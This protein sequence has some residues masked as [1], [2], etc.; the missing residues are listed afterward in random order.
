MP[1]GRRSRFAP[2]ELK[3]GQLGSASRRRLSGAF[4]PRRAGPGSAHRRPCQRR[5]RRPLLRVAPALY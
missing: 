5:G 3:K 4:W 1:F 2:K